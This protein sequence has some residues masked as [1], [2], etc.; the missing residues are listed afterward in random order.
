VAMGYGGAN[1]C[2]QALQKLSDAVSVN[3]R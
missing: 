1:E 3:R 2:F